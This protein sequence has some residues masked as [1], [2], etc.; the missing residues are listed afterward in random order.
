MEIR[1]LRYFWA[2]A[3]EG[4][5]SRASRILNIT[6]P[7][8][9]RQIKELEERIGAPLFHREK[10]RLSLTKDGYFLKERAEEILALDEKL[11]QAFSAQ[12]NEQLS[13]TIS[14]GCV[15]ADNSDT[16]AMLLEELI[17]DYPQIQFNLVTGTSDDISDRLEKGILDL[18][19][20]L[21]PVILNEV[22]TL[23]LPREERWG[24]L[25]SKEMFIAEK[26]FL[27]PEDIKGLPILCSSRSEVQNLLSD[28]S[29]EPLDQLNIVGNFNLIFNVLP[30]VNHKVGAALSVEGAILD[31]R[32]EEAVF[33]PLQPS[34]KTHCVLVWK[35]RV[36][37]PAVQELIN[38]FNHAFKL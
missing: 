33:I 16:V 28:W 23:I 21:E 18:A 2:V 14:I 38:R 24:F 19:I 37:T 30:L 32:L 10:N 25:V 12:R 17:S 31:R 34:V 9:S 6:Q 22:E 26:E 7:T 4:N 8:L 5:I 3:Q 15:E 29:G 35:K 27:K 13:G 1:L 36:Q 20:L 11:E